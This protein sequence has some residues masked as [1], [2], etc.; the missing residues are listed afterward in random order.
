MVIKLKTKFYDGN[1]LLSLLDIN[2]E[3][4]EIYI[5][6]SNRNAGKTTYFSKYAINRFLKYGEKFCLLYRYNYD[7]ENAGEKFFS[8]VQMFFP[9]KKMISRSCSEGK[10]SELFLDDKKCG[11][12]L[13][14]NNAKFY[15]QF[16][17]YFADIMLILFDEFQPEGSAD[18]VKNEILMTKLLEFLVENNK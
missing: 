1:K 5:C 16:S 4:P 8:N 17:N 6:T 13:A 9:D 2:G 10:Y 11:Y 3:K 14:L 15:R 7:I 12:A 18:Y